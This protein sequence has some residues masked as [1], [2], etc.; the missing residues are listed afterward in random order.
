MMARAYC[1]M[2]WSAAV[3]STTHLLISLDLLVIRCV[4]FL[5]DLTSNIMISLFKNRL[6]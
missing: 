2:V 5:N 6:Y 1:V 3:V 4:K